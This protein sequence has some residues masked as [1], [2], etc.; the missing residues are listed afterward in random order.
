MVCNNQSSNATSS[1]SKS[2]S[3]VTELHLNTSNPLQPPEPLGHSGKLQMKKR[4]LKTLSETMLGGLGRKSVQINNKS[5]GHLQV[6]ENIRT[7]R[8]RDH[9]E[10]SVFTQLKLNNNVTVPV[11]TRVTQT[12]PFHCFNSDLPSLLNSLTTS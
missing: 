4:L 10:K 3:S 2:D 6:V 9:R 11:F 12:V 5:C 1:S 7:F 8:L